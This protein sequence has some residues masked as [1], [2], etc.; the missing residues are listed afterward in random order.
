MKSFKVGEVGVLSQERT[1]RV[2]HPVGGSGKRKKGFLSN[3]YIY[4]RV[5]VVVVVVRV[6]T[7]V[8]PL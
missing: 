5:V 6:L 2:R 4:S 7:Q 3:L 1:A 8:Y